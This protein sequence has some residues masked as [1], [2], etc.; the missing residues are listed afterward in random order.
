M[1]RRS[2]QLTVRRF[3]YILPHIRAEKKCGRHEHLKYSPPEIDGQIPQS[4]ANAMPLVGHHKDEVVDTWDS[5]KRA[6]H[7]SSCERTW[8]APIAVCRE[9][10]PNVHSG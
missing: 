9:G 6:A 7:L 5:K 3:K 8:E 1:R 4:G 10:K 2:K